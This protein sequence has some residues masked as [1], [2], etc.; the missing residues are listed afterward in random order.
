MSNFEIDT[1]D[2]CV[3]RSA[4]A[5]VFYWR[6]SF[7]HR[8]RHISLQCRAFSIRT[9]W[10]GRRK[11]SETRIDTVVA[12]CQVH[13]QS[14]LS[15]RQINLIIFSSLSSSSSSFACSS[16]SIAVAVCLPHKYSSLSFGRWWLTWREGLCVSLVLSSNRSRLLEL[17]YVLKLAAVSPITTSIH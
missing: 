7:N 12:H 6:T 13:A 8:R 2:V 5:C 16:V 3:F 14:I 15:P 1:F 10:W 11:K 17:G 4:H 9:G